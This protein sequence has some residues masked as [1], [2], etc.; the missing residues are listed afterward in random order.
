MLYHATITVGV[1]KKNNTKIDYAKTA[2]FT[3]YFG[4]KQETPQNPILTH[5]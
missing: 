3:F 1:N 2:K 5:N 4:D